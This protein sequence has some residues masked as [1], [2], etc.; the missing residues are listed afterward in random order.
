MVN[1]EELG[2]LVPSLDQEIEWNLPWLPRIGE[3]ISF[4]DKDLLQVPDTT[5]LGGLKF[6]VKLV[7]YDYKKSKWH[8]TV[9]CE[10]VYI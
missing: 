10:T 8:P 3:Y 1:E 2:S 9:I 7:S 6:L 4:E 5:Y